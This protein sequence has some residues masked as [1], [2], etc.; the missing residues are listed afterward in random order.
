MKLYSNFLIFL[1]ALSEA[2]QYAKELP[3]F[4]PQMLAKLPTYVIINYKPKITFVC[5]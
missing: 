3:E 4:G 5:F 1:L 2:G